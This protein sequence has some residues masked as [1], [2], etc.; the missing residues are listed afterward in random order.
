MQCAA[1]GALNVVERIFFYMPLQHS[2]VLEVQEESVAAF[3]RLAAECAPELH[4]VF[5]AARQSATAHRELIARFGRFPHRNR[6]LGRASTPEELRYLTK[7]E[8]TFGQ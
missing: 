5:E 4:P 1:D 8:E 3:T 7:D 2:E 6:I